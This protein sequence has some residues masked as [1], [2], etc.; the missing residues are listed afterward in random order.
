V[1]AAAKSTPAEAPAFDLATEFAALVGNEARAWRELAQV[2]EIDIGSGDP[3]T[4]AYR[5]QI[6]CY[7]TGTATLA[8]IRQLDRP[9]VLTL[10]DGSNRAAHALLVG[11]SEKSATLRIDGV[12]RDVPL[13]A[14]ADY[15]RGEYATFWRA[16]PGYTGAIGS[17]RAGPA[18]RWLA[19]QLASVRGAGR[20][21]AERLDDATLKGWIHAFQLT[22]GLPSDGVAGPI[23]LMQLNRAIGV[24][25]PRLGGGK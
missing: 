22:Q 12:A 2:W 10:R 20:P 4:A 15:W 14:L 6:L 17:G 13:F 25:E 3:C 23:T 16:P 24:D 21:V 19:L 1:A 7:R 18:A 9:G 8:L 11:L 5:R